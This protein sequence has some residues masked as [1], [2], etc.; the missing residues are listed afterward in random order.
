MNMIPRGE[1][2]NLLLRGLF[3]VG[4]GEFERLQCA[5]SIAPKN[6]SD[7]P[8]EPIPYMVTDYLLQ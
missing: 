8:P 7:G 3:E 5:S 1:G 6:L 4:V 2:H